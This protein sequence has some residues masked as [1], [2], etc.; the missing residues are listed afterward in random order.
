[1]ST[2]NKKHKKKVYNFRQWQDGDAYKQALQE[3]INDLKVVEKG[4]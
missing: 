3:L 1:M 2:L 4:A